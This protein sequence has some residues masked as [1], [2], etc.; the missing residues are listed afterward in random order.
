MPPSITC[1]QITRVFA[2][3]GVVSSSVAT[4]AWF[5]PRLQPPWQPADGVLLPDATP[6]SCASSAAPDRLVYGVTGAGSGWRSANAEVL[7]LREITG[8][9]R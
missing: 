3:A 1:K 6:F 8:T 4:G 2:G 7:V 5:L 9:S